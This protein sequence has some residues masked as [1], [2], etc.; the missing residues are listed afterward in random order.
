MTDERDLGHDVRLGES[1]ERRARGGCDARGREIGMGV[2][3]G[4]RG[5]ARDGFARRTRDVSRTR[6]GTFRGYEVVRNTFGE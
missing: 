3:I 5:T 2:G 4:L 6:R 1:R